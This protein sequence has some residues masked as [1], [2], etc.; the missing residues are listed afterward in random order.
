[1]TAAKIGV[2]HPVHDLIEEVRRVFLEKGFSEVENLL[3]IPEEDVYK[4]YGSEAPVILDRC[5]YL[6][7]LPRP[8]IGLG[9]KQVDAIK[10][11][12][13]DFDFDSFTKILREYREG[14]IEGDN[15]TEDMVSRL[16]I[17]M[18][19][20]VK[21]IG[22]IPQFKTIT[23]VPS[24]L[25]LR[26]HMTAA[27]YQTLSSVQDTAEYPIRLFSIGL[28]FRR[29]QKVDATHLRA[30]YGASCVIMDKGLSLEEGKKTSADILSALGF[31]KNSFDLK[32]ATAN[33]YEKGTEYEVYSDKIEIADCGL[34]SKASL[35][36][37]EIKYPVFNLGFGLERMLMLRLKKN[38]IREVMYPQLYSALELSDKDITEKIDIARKPAT[39][40]GKKLAAALKKAFLEHGEAPSPCK[41]LAYGG[42][43]L[44]K[45]VEVFAVEREEGTKL[46][47]PAAYNDLFVY[48]G[49]VYGIP[50]DA[51]KLDKSMIEVRE[52]GLSVGI[53][54]LDALVNLFAAD[55]EEAL[56][57]GE[58]EGFF[59]IK[60]AKTPSDVNIGV[61]PVA[62]RYISSVNKSISV[63]GPI[64]TA[65]EFRVK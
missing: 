56:K 32:K 15:L 37:Y 8:D 31:G 49:G 52:K 61:N 35:S 6:A 39:E 63:K 58:S 17:G 40:E 34:Y 45:T 33:Y 23:P 18:D 65:I 54:V 10:E 42:S 25:T 43:F 36:S 62:R 47:G 2:S 48:D 38:D 16:R 30:H 60:M 19:D 57:R 11:I 50:K 24:K 20:A 13:A 44:G 46:L 55:V 41:F 9:K 27:W 5:Y 59:Q 21:I 51:G 14:G 1:M 26:S 53:S 22:L 3:F 7:G 28:R 12:K 29:E 4:Q 64:F